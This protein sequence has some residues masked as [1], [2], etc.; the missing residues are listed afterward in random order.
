MEDTESNV[1]SIIRA[2][3]TGWRL[4]HGFLIIFISETT[5]SRQNLLG[6]G[7]AGVTIWEPL[8]K[9][10][11]VASILKLFDTHKYKTLVVQ[12]PRYVPPDGPSI[13]A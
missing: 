3:A 10:K 4:L 9:G 5:F 6:F 7:L 1:V 2:S 8:R 11:P 13:L 12:V